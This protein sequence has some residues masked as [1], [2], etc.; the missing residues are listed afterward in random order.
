MKASEIASRYAQALYQLASEQT[1]QDETFSQIRALAD[2]LSAEATIAQFLTS[3]L[4]RPSEKEKAF[5]DS[6]KHL[7]IS[8][9][10]KN[11]VFL[12]AKKQRL[13]IFSDIVTAYQNIADEKHG[14]VR[15]VVRSTTVLPPEERKRIEQTVN[16]VTNKQALLI[17]KEDPSLLGGLVADVGSFTFDDSL[18]S[19][20]KRM[21]EQLTRRSV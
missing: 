14:V 18:A 6:F 11:F 1:K 17:Y 12:L 2:A 9:T 15:G 13:E 16:R 10:V 5:A 4:V 20:L 3:P 8:E 19:H 21:N 7:S